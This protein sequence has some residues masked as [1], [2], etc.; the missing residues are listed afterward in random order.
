MLSWIIEGG[1]INAWT[2][3]KVNCLPFKISINCLVLLF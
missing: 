3:L 1:F 2:I